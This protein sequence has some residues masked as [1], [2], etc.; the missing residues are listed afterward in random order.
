M[1]LQDD[2]RLPQILEDLSSPFRTTEQEAGHH[3]DGSLRSGPLCDRRGRCFPDA[4]VSGRALAAGQQRGAEQSA[5][6]RRQEVEV[7]RKLLLPQWSNAL[8]S[9][10]KWVEVQRY[11]KNHTISSSALRPERSSFSARQDNTSV[12]CSHERQGQDSA[13]GLRRRKLLELDGQLFACGVR[14][15][16]EGQLEL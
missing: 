4:L 12:K 16:L 13:P 8:A 6:A 15:V 7:F 10:Q 1:S 2:E 11:K 14:G 5:P 9:G 3:E